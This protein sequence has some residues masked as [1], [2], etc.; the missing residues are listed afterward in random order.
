MRYDEYRVKNID[1]L[2][3]IK[4]CQ[5]L[6]YRTPRMDAMIINIIKGVCMK[7]QDMSKD[8]L[9]DMK[10]HAFI[11]SCDAYKTFNDI[12]YNNAFAYV[13]EICKRGV[14][15][16]YNQIY[17]IIYREGNKYKVNNISISSF[18]DKKKE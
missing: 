15:D 5:G 8:D 3:E 12:R 18:T 4:L 11:K 7:F 1:L 6:G 10:Q 16:G 14:I 13:T 9:M 17:Q 2:Y